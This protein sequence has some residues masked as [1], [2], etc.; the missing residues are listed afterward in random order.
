MRRIQS[1]QTA[2]DEAGHERWTADDQRRFDQRFREWARRT[3]NQTSY[4]LRLERGEPP[5]GIGKSRRRR[6]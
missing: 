2:W 5:F 6:A 4:E 1:I 3:G